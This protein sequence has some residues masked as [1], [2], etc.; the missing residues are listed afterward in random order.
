MKNKWFEWVLWVKC[1]PKKVW[2]VKKNEN[3]ILGESSLCS[4]QIIQLLG[5][6]LGN[7]IQVALIMDTLSI[8]KEK[9]DVVGYSNDII[10]NLEEIMYAYCLQRPIYLCIFSAPTIF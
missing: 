6:F 8:D 5:R 4:C 2:T 10:I 3:N 1:K 9:Y 7:C